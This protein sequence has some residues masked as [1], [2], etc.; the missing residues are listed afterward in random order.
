[1]SASG[2]LS[3]FHP[4]VRAWFEQTYSVPSHVQA[5]AWP[6][7][8]AGRHILATA[9]TG[10]G[11]T[12]AAFLW[13]I[14]TLVSGAWEGGAL[15]VLYVSPLKALGA[16]I[17]RN[18][19]APLA[20]IQRA[21]E[22][23]GTGVYVPRVAMRSGD[24]AGAERRNMLRYPP[25]ILVTTPE[26]LNIMLTGRHAPTYFAGLRCVILDEIHAVAGSHR[27]VHLMTG[28]ERLCHL[29]GEIQR[30]ALSATVQP[31]SVI[32]RFVGGFGQGGRARP[33]TV[34][35]SPDSK[36]YRLR[37]EH[38]ETASRDAFWA[39]LSLRVSEI[40]EREH[41]VL[42]FANSRRHAEHFTL[43]LNENRDAPLAWAHHGSL[44]REVRQD[45]EERLKAGSVPAIVSTSTL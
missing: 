40:V 31:L 1:M 4:A 18:L 14:H 6:E 27:G 22:E 20:G 12:L 43:R 7:I 5:R 16:D 13:A 21:A 10:S 15:R 30:I 42:V 23:L 41:P 45:V 32:S 28:V 39:D 38:A 35:Q 36:D 24:S 3:R 11:K 29:A 17:Q 33:V 26:S 25:E 2:V 34:L 37:V 9:P 44:S 8:S 19:T